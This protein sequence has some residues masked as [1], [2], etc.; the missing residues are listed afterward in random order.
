MNKI[1]VNRDPREEKMIIA[2]GIR[3]ALAEKNILAINLISSP[4]SGKNNAA[5]ETAAGPR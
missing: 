1:V 2:E 4:G 5:R 3:N